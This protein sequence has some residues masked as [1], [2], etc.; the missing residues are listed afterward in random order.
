MATQRVTVQVESG[1]LAAGQA[2]Q[3]DDLAAGAAA[4]R[5]PGAPAAG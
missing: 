3:A 4:A 1:T 2:V 5:A